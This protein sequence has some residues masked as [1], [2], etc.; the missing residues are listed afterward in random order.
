MTT[1]H[2]KVVMIMI[3]DERPLGKSSAEEVKAGN[4]VC[5]IEWLRSE[6]LQP[7]NSNKLLENSIP[8]IVFVYMS[9]CFGILYFFSRNP[10]MAMGGEENDRNMTNIIEKEIR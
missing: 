4:I 8:S 5:Y 1:T 2:F 9:I 3:S 10:T 6:E 7:C